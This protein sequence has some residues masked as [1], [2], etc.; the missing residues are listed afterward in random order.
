MK[1]TWPKKIAPWGDVPNANGK[2]MRVGAAFVKAFY[3][4]LHPWRH[5]A[6]DFNHN[7]FPGSDEYKA[8]AEPRNVAAFGALE[9][10]ENDGVYFT[11]TRWV[12]PE[13][14]ATKNYEDLSPVL[15]PDANGDVIAVM[16]VGLVRNGAIPGITLD[17]ANAFSAAFPAASTQTH[18][19]HMDYK[20]ALM[21]AYGIAAKKADGADLTDDEI[22]AAVKAA[23]K[24]KADDDAKAKE[25]ADKEAKAKAEAEKKA[26]EKDKDGDGGADH[27]GEA[28]GARMDALER[29]RAIDRARMEGR[30]IGVLEKFADKLTPEELA[31]E[32]AKCPPGAVAFSPAVPEGGKN[33]PST[34]T[35]SDARKA[36]REDMANQLGLDPAKVKW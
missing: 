7:T 29:G 21:E 34:E 2:K 19:P 10:R 13:E 12:T 33:T 14:E 36:S 9:I 24:K 27:K 32:I 18:N 35:V 5:V 16:S 4:A 6:L 30:D 1:F 17:P 28:M 26:K 8:T 25:D 15:V 11:P 20:K 3:N 31:A 22:E 23:K